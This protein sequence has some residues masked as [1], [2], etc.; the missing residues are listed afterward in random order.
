MNKGKCKKSSSVTSIIYE[1]KNLSD[2]YCNCK[3][4]YKFTNNFKQFKLKNKVNFTN[5]SKNNQDDKKKR[6]SP[7]PRPRN[8]ESCMCA[9]CIK[10]ESNKVIKS[11]RTREISTLR[12]VIHS[13]EILYHQGNKY[14]SEDIAPYWKKD[15]RMWLWKSVRLERKRKNTESKSLIHFPSLICPF[16]NLSHSKIK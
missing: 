4:I 6:M 10:R 14:T 8:I 1:N 7:T 12:L 2:F 5:Y 11:I 15:S 16:H 3:D 13:S 9:N